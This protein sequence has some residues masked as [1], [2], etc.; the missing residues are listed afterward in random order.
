MVCYPSKTIWQNALSLVLETSF[1]AIQFRVKKIF[2]NTFYHIR[3][4]TIL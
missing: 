3:L 1:S 2:I 4:M